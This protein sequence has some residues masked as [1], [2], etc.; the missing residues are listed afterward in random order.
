MGE[1]VFIQG[2]H[3]LAESAIRAGCKLFFGY[4]ITP[5][6]EV[7]EYY[8]KAMVERPDENIMYIQGETEV[9]VF[10]MVAGAVATGN[11]SMTVT[12]GP[13]FSLGQ[14]TMSF[15]AAG[16]LPAVIVNIM[17]PGPADGDIMVAQGDYFQATR[18][19]GHG[20][21]NNLVLAPFS[22]Q[23]LCVMMQ[24]SFELAEKYSN[25]VIIL[26]DGMLSKRR[27]SVVLNDFIT[28]PDPLSKP[29]VLRGCGKN[30]EPRTITTC[31]QG[32]QQWEEYNLRL[33]EKFKKIKENEVRFETYQVEDADVVMVAIGSMA[34]ICLS[35]M[36][37][38]RNEGLKVGMIRP[39]SVWPF[40]D[41]AFEGLDG[42]K[43]LVC[44]LNAGQM[45]DDVK[46]AVE[47]KRDVFFY[48]RLG[49]VVPTPA[50]ILQQIKKMEVK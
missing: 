50:E 16:D 11:R 17:R 41:K 10:N 12:A 9:A 3:A 26:S 22:I 40:P 45:V 32:T 18:G 2:N 6:S 24:E 46:L 20:D 1:R 13:G 25:P 36:K 39:I 19:G 15:M 5:T 44:E 21:Y 37:M 23:E 29:N 34:R 49:G 38:A 35:A 14:E 42:K 8:A 28:P 7:S 33:Q 31:S 27:E 47:N 48:G 4:P 43:F 30:G